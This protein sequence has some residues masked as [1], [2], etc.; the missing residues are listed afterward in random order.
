MSTPY[1]GEIRPFA[2]NF[3]INGWALCDGS[4]MPIANNPALF[5]LIGTTYGGDGQTTFALPDLRG[6][7]P[8][9]QGNGGTGTNYVIGQT[10]GLETV[11]LNTQ[12]IPAH[13]HTAVANPAAGT[14]PGPGGNILAT[15]N[16]TALYSPRPPATAMAAA[17]IQPT[18]GSQ[19]HQNMQPFLTITFIIALQGIFPSQN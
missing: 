17:A 1:L 19:P 12:Q 7:F 5:E 15:S 3:A 10:G 2:G 9:H 14:Q 8:I 6:R 18:G 13:T 4:L 11:T 16:G